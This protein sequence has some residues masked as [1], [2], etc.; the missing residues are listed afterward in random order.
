M[1]SCPSFQKV[2]ALISYLKFSFC[3][4]KSKIFLYGFADEYIN[5]CIWQ[6]NCTEI[7]AQHPIQAQH[8]IHM[9]LNEEPLL[10][11]WMVTFFKGVKNNSKEKSQLT[12][13]GILQKDNLKM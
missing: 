12:L 10:S 4:I 9:H 11:L 6:C 7:Q 1:F 2:R 5:S 3:N 13:D 8:L